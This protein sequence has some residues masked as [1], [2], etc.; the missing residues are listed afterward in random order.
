MATLVDFESKYTVLL[1]Y[2]LTHAPNPQLK[3]LLH[4]DRDLQ[5]EQGRAERWTNT[6]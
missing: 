1:L 2:G 5:T 4:S 6:L 3:Q